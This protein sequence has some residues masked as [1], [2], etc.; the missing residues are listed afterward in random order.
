VYTTGPS[1]KDAVTT[2]HKIRIRSKGK[3]INPPISYAAGS[4][5]ALVGVAYEVHFDAA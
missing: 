3:R 1:A 4:G 2:E 5:K